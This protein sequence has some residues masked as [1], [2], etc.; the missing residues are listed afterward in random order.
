MESLSVQALQEGGLW[1]QKGKNAV[2][3]S[4]HFYFE[5]MESTG[6]GLM[7]LEDLLGQVLC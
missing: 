1:V 3:L 7:L 5:D 4:I 2:Q 6:A